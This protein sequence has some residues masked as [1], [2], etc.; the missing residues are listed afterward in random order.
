MSPV[1][2]VSVFG[3]FTTYVLH[4][5]NDSFLTKDSF[6]LELQAFNFSEVFTYFQIYLNDHHFQMLLWACGQKERHSIDFK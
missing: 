2:S 6:A 5:N 3:A 1:W 4:A